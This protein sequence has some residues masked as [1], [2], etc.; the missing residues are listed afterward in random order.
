MVM[1]GSYSSATEQRKARS[2]PSEFE[3]HSSLMRSIP[4]GHRFVNSGGG[5]QP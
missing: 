1:C 3:F 2:R 4:R 5:W